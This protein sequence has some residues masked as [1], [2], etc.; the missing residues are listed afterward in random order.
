MFHM[1]DNIKEKISS[2]NS[3]ILT[4]D[5]ITVNYNKGLEYKKKDVNILGN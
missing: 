2:L 4:V 3:F 1:N 5:E